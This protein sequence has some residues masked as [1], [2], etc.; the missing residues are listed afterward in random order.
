MIDGCQNQSRCGS[1]KSCAIRRVA[2]VGN[3]N[4]GKST[5]FNKLT[6]GN[7]HVGNWPGVTV[8][9][10]SGIAFN[11]IEITDLPGIYA[12]TA[13][14]EAAID[15]CIATDFILSRQAD[16]VVNVVDA[17][18][19]E[20]HLYLTLQLLAWGVPVI[21]VLNRLDAARQLNC[22]ALALALHCPVI[23]LDANTGHGIEALKAAIQH[24]QPSRGPLLPYPLDVQTVIQQLN[25]QNAVRY[26]ETDSE[27]LKKI[28]PVERCEQ[29]LQQQASIR[30]SMKEDV[31]ILIADTR[32]R[33]IQHLL[34][35]CRTVSAIAQTTWT[36]R[37][38]Q[39]VLNRFLGIP[40]FLAVMYLLFGFSMCVGGWLQNFFDTGSQWLFVD[41][42]SQ[43]L[44]QVGAPAW[45]TALIANGAGKGVN[46]VITFIPVLTTM[47][48]FLTLL[49]D[50]G[51]MVRAAFVIDRCMRA[52]GL[53][54][55]AFVPMMIGFGCNVPAIMAARTLEYK[56]DRILTILMTPFMSCGARLT[57]YAVFTAA[58]F[59][60]QGSYV[61][62]VL[63]LLGIG[64]A[65]LTGF[66]LRK[67]VLQGQSSPLMMELPAY[68]RPR[69]KPLFRQTG[70][71]LQ[72]FVWRAG[73]LIIPIC[74]LI[75]ALNTLNVDGTLNAGEG[76]AHSLLSSVGQMLTPIFAPMGIHLDN[77]PATVGL[78]T[79][80]LAK[81]V[82]IGT[83]N[84]LYAQMAPGTATYTTL[85]HAF[86]GGIG[87]FAYLLF[88]LL[89]FPCVS[90]LAVMLRELNRGWAIFSATW[91][92]AL[93]YGTAVLFYQTATW[94][95]HPLSSSLWIL[96]IVGLFSFIIMVLRFIANRDET[97]RL[98]PA[99]ESS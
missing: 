99:E 45:L 77:W 14:Q 4:S 71:R 31:D 72:G 66:L 13:N 75:G 80:V 85:A 9:R 34:E 53:P 39:V 15:E 24:Y 94:L 20:R 52:L 48:F 2:L 59:P 51:Y 96:S 69:L 76:D 88:V 57:I 54:G 32:Y 21:V 82:V 19:L 84:T 86:D 90:T 78:V 23:A 65:I 60:Q 26:L 28:L 97:I 8:E 37:I 35:K 74:M 83:L 25:D 92:M 63:Y 10:K 18:C 79:G 1:A 27:T 70:Q 95:R 11:H 30:E 47:F 17:S 36:E 73:K 44:S 56:R 38:D 12:L 62:F 41:C 7:Q 67:T 49:E 91:M 61:V 29:I 81:E 33:F 58:F 43:G 93:A 50:S 98:R 68:Q 6:G 87:A 46:T 3:P 42:I 16:V 64:M 5:L 89:Y 22:Q 40:I 55:K